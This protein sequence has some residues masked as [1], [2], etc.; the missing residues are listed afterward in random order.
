MSEFKFMTVQEAAEYLR[1]KPLAVYRKVKRK[2]IP[3]LKAGRS[4][5]F[6]KEDID[7]WLRWGGP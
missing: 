1:L 3:F 7:H 4:I 5:R 2:E 6:K